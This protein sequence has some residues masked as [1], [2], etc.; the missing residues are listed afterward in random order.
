VRALSRSGGLC[1]QSCDDSFEHMSTLYD[2]R[3]Y[4]V[5]RSGSAAS[6][7]VVVPIIQE[8]IHPRSVLDVGCGI[9]TWATVWIA[10]GVSD[11]IGVDGD[12]VDKELLQLP[13]ERFIGHN[14]S[15]PLDVGRKFDLVTC[16][17]VAEHLPAASASTLVESLVRH[18]EV[19]VFSAAIPG[20]EGA[21][22][23]NEQWPS[24]WVAHFARAGYQPFDLLRGRLWNNGE[25]E[26]W[27]QQNCLLFATNDAAE[28]YKMTPTTSPLDIVHPV[29]FTRTL[30][31]PIALSTRVSNKA[32]A[33]L[34]AFGRTRV[35]R[36]IRRLKRSVFK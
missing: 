22:H 2:D 3:F 16:L 14:L 35:G 13:R 24:Y 15:D 34:G 29:L 21:G 8:L 19:V 17:E 31:R 20:Q 33:R 7:R 26:W 6:A 27:Y 11:V 18:T 10:S 1:D 9:G 12:Y 25:V 23:I 28:R 32:R 4:E 36:P 30:A 5:H